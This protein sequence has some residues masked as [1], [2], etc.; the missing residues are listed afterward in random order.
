MKNVIRN[1]FNPDQNEG[2]T[3]C[4]ICMCEYEPNDEIIELPC[5]R[6]HFFH[7]GCI[8][9]WLKKNN[10]CPMCKKPIT[11]EDIKNQKKMKRSEKK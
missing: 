6:R 1:K 2:N 4:I 9:N 5:D 11:M 3:E 10:S 8:E 7:A